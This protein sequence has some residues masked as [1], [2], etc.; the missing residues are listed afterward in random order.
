VKCVEV[1]LA[2]CDCL[3]ILGLVNVW[4]VLGR[5]C[6]TFVLGGLVCSFVGE[7]MKD[8]GTMAFAYYKDGKSDPTFL[9]FGDAL[10]EVK[11]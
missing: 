2:G 5:G 1:D 9:Y 3:Q 4:I 10:K 6:E 7:S 11:C 8:D